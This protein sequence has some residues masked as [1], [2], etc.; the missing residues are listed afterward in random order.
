ML[1]K[2]SLIK[3]FKVVQCNK[4]GQWQVMGGLL[5][6]CKRCNKSTKLRLKSKFGLN[7]KLIKS[8]D[9]GMEAQKFLKVFNE[10]KTKED[11]IGFKSYAGTEKNG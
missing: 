8:F 2:A 11:F 5:F 6:K 4:C 9:T 7:L 10:E 3:K 1:S